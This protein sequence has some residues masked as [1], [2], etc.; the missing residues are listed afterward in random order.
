MARASGPV[1]YRGRWA[2][3]REG[4][5][6]VSACVAVVAAVIGTV[7]LLPAR[8]QP[9]CRLESLGSG[10]VRQ[11]TDGRTFLLDDGREVRLAGIEVPSPEETAALSAAAPPSDASAA[12]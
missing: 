8:A 7:T 10:Q 2:R 12:A 5:V 11:V 3:C 4:R 6:A 1:A 9:S